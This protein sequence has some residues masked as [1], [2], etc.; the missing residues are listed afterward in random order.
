MTSNA[1]RRSAKEM[2][3][4]LGEHAK[5]VKDLERKS[6]DMKESDVSRAQYTMPL[7]KEMHCSL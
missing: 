1:S 6:K 2:E 4:G 7:R 3:E 5:T